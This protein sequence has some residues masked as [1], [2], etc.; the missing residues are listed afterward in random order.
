MPVIFLRAALRN[1]RL[2]SG[3]PG[4]VTTVPKISENESA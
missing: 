3:T 2:A 1:C 4:E